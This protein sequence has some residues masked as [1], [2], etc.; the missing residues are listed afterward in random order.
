MRRATLKVSGLGCESCVVPSKEKFLKVQ[1]ISSVKVLGALVE[2][3]YDENKL[4]L[5]ELIER[6]GVKNFYSV[7][8]VS[9]EESEKES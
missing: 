9:D 2:V 8:V 3:T 4:T 1:G 5:Q 7:K 6:S